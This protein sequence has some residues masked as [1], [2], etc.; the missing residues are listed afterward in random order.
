MQQET[1]SLI[2]NIPIAKLNK[3]GK[4]T[5]DFWMDGITLYPEKIFKKPEIYS[6]T[7]TQLKLCIDR[8]N[9]YVGFICKEPLS[10]NTGTSE[11]TTPWQSDNV[12][13]CIANLKYPLWYKLFVVGANNIKLSRMIDEDSWK[14][15]VKIEEK[16]WFVKLVIPLKKLGPLDDKIVINVLRERKEAKEVITLQNLKERA[17]EIENFYPLATYSSLINTPWTFRVKNTSVG[18]GWAT[19]LPSKTKLFYRIKGKKDWQTQDNIISTSPCVYST[20]IPS[21]KENTV[22]QYYIPGMKKIGHIKTLTSKEKDFSFALTCD[23]H[24]KTNLLTNLLKDQQTKASDLFFMLGDQLDASLALEL[25]FSS[26][27][28][29]VVKNWQKPFYCL[30]GNHEGRDIANESFYSLFSNG[31]KIG[32]DGFLH[33]GVYFV[34]LDTDHDNGIPE[35]YRKEQT[36]FLKKT[37]NS[38]EYQNAQ[39]RVLLTHIPVTFKCKRWGDDQITMLNELSNEEYNSFDVAFSGHTHIFCQTLPNSNQTY[40][41]NEQYNNL[42]IL[43]PTSFPEFT[44]SLLGLFLVKKINSNLFI[45]IFDKEKNLIIKHKIKQ[46]KR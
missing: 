28:N 22:Y 40:S 3:K 45:E 34:I 7:Q 14:S 9:L 37:I 23:V 29:T 32:Y 38:K 18:I 36:L 44:G 46:R 41:S 25:H 13:F 6:K 8:K 11:D 21:L 42:P 19:K 31:K 39:F 1:I 12:E 2:P 4:L 33:K 17:L 15:F 27:L 16:L 30:Y 10:V 26:Y 24:T 35:D 43:R 20:I 5:E